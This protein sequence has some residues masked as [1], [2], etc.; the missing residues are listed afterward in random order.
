MALS[1]TGSEGDV[2]NEQQL[3]L[4]LNLNTAMTTMT[5]TT[6]SRYSGS[7]N[8]PNVSA[9]LAICLIPLEI[10]YIT[11]VRGQPQVMQSPFL[12]PLSTSPFSYFPSSSPS[13]PVYHLYSV[14]CHSHSSY[15]VG[16]LSQRILTSFSLDLL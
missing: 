6:G 1:V 10:N 12:F 5:M 9:I 8:C 3:D 2:L 13:L 11:S 16:A 14:T 15:I 7:K 4:N